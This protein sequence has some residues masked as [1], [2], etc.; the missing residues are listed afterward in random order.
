MPLD[1][2]QPI[3]KVNL[4]SGL[5]RLVGCEHNLSSDR[6]ETKLHLVQS[7]L[8]EALGEEDYDK[9]AA[10]YR[11]VLQPTGFEVE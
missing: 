3:K 6:S 11:R 5:Y 7:S 8:D 10:V 1:T 4:V 9:I 2:E